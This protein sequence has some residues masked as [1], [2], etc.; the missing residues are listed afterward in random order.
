MK[1]GK[2][3]RE[4]YE[5]T[6]EEVSQLENLRGWPGVAFD[7]WRKVATRLG[8]DPKTIIHDFIDRRKFTGLPAGHG[9]WW[10]FPIPL[11]CLKRPP[12]GA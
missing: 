3:R 1:R 4:T 2:I 9:K 10:C 6:A 7:F 12:A 11:E 8:V 5:L